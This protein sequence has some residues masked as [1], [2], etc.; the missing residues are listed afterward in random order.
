MPRAAFKQS[1]V[2]RL[3]RAAKAEGY[4]APAVR[5]TAGG[6]LILLTEGGALPADE[7]AGGANEWDEV[8]DQPP[9]Q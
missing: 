6:D 9:L 2:Q 1:E 3:I 5:K 4:A 8:L 7:A